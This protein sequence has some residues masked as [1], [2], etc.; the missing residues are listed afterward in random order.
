MQKSQ[1]KP[2]KISTFVRNIE[3]LTFVRAVRG[4]LVN[5][6]PVLIIGAFALVFRFLPID[7]YRHFIETFAGGV[8]DKIFL[9][10]N[11]ATF[12]VLSVF[13]TY[14]ISR[15]YMKVKAD[16]DTVNGGAVF[17]SLLAF[18]LLAGAFLDDFGSV[19]LG[20]KSMVLAIVAGLGASA[21][22]LKADRFFRRRRTYLFSPGADREFNRM[23]ASF[24]PILVVAVTFG[25]LNTLILHISH[26]ESIH[27]LY[28]RAMNALFSPGGENPGFFK[29]FFFVLVSSVLW[30]FGVHGS[31]ALEGV[32]DTYFKNGLENGAIL[33]KEFF[34]CFVLMGGCGTTI[35]LL[36]ALLAFSRNRAQW[37]LGLTA[38]F[39]MVFNIN[40]LMVFGLP[41]VFNPIMLIPFLTVPLACYSVSYLAV[42]SGIVPH[43]ANTI[44]WTTPILLGG[45]KACG[46]R[47]LLLQLVLVLIGVAI[48]YPFVRLLD[49]ESERNSREHFSM[50]MD[51]FREHEQDLQNKRVTDLDNVYSDVAK[52]LCADLRDGLSRH[53]T[54]YYQPQYHYDGRCVGVE[55]LLRWKH[56]VHGILYP[57]LVIKL[58]TESNI[59]ARFEEAV[60]EK[61][62]SERP[63][64]LAK[65]GPDVKLSINVTGGTIATP[66]FVQFCRKLNEQSPFKG[67]NVCLE[68][69][70]QTAL[71][72][73]DGTR[74]QLNE[75][76]RM[77]LLLAIDDFS[78][79]QTSLHYLKDS[80]FDVIKIDGSLVRG[81]NTSQNCREIISS[82]TTLSR[83]LS[84]PVIAEFV[85]T[86]EQ[87]EILH[88]IGCDSYQGYLYSPAVPVE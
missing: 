26:A 24:L 78:M 86:A 10:V 69:T 3:Q 16:P 66:R 37:R 12:G 2:Q 45:Y 38:A 6:I 13:M 87:R 49:R 30:F 68:V 81:L 5:M 59:L 25:V 71:D 76:R 64:I 8:L 22:Y 47:G 1:N 63:A 72:L 73:G 23:L 56:P 29:G 36:I 27:A 55:A 82:I 11:S 42:Y 20:V 88:E 14:S 9:Y 44:D 33:S 58:A 51:F 62:L 19:Q 43:I 34:D 85:E 28:I 17:A 39:P 31:D 4:G 40:E 7:G 65:F 15:S 54:L 46:I 32:M 84:L 79:G 57:P 41:I 53:M 75:L 70:E 74:E 83:S 48:Y 18:F 35:C 21:L 67:K 80:V 77:G 61:A 60:I 50:F 52:S